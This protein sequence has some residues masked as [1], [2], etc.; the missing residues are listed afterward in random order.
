M[1]IIN[2]KQQT[3]N[4]IKDSLKSIPETDAAIPSQDNIL[5]LLW[6]QI[7]RHPGARIGGIVLVIIVIS[8]TILV[9]FSPYDPE[10][11]VITEQLQPPSLK[12][13][14]G[15]DPLG[16]DLLT[17]ILYGGRISLLVS[18]GVVFIIII[19]GIPIGAIAGTYGGVVDDI[20]MRFTDA[21][22]TLP[23]LLVLI[24][25]SSILRS[26]ELPL[27]ESNSIFTIAVVIGL[28]RWM[29][30]ARLVRAGF[31]ILREKE[32]VLASKSL[33]ASNFRIMFRHLLPNALGPLIVTCTLEIG[34][35]IMQ[36]SGLSFLG[37]GIRPPT[38]SW[39]TL[40]ADAQVHL[41]RHPWL[42]IFPGLMIFLTIVSINYIGDAIRDAF[43][44]HK[45]I[46]SKG[47]EG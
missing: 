21:V 32:F 40:L 16:R 41:N 44:P 45:T 6:K 36:E 9:N 35:A 20:L 37:F 46:V 47:R 25:F 30:L 19:L 22:L 39:G 42:A 28:L 38:P 12:H 17:R 3:A 11:S 34:Y 1:K 4:D 26:V 31:L 15:T 7:R 18:L 5:K 24:M 14:F 23:S 8:C 2:L 27:F 10:T 43:D 13:P 33:G 29:T